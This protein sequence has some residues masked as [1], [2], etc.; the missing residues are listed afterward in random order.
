MVGTARLCSSMDCVPASPLVS[1]SRRSPYYR[2]AFAC[3]VGSGA[4]ATSETGRGREVGDRRIVFGAA[5]GVHESF[6]EE[7]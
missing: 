5:E 7:K 4:M 6:I 2:A 3:V 1:A